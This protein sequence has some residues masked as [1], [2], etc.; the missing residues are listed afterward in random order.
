MININCVQKLAYIIQISLPIH[1]IEQSF[2]EKLKL[3]CLVMKFHSLYRNWE[4]IFIFKA[5]HYWKPTRAKHIMFTP[6]H[7]ISLKNLHCVRASKT[8]ILKRL[9]M[10]RRES[11]LMSWVC[12]IFFYKTMINKTKVITSN[13]TE[14]SPLLT[15]MVQLWSSRFLHFWFSRVLFLHCWYNCVSF[16]PS[17]LYF[18]NLFLKLVSALV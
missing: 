15:V 12:L 10:F 14:H 5:E 1:S 9:Q 11:R 3:A 17:T 2:P 4:F 6:S 8:T 18:V 13:H 7:S 16:Q